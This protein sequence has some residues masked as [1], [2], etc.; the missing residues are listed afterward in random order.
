[1]SS[2][3][4]RMQR[5]A[6][7]AFARSRPRPESETIQEQ[8]AGQPASA[9][10]NSIEPSLSIDQF[11]VVEGISR[12][13]FYQ[14]LQRGE[15]PDLTHIGKRRTISPESHRRWRRKR[16]KPALSQIAEQS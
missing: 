3:Q 8:S 14:M 2:Q 15:A 16:T 9:Q 13:G 7:A 10:L 6:A 11:C 4:S 12:S 1:M 5:R